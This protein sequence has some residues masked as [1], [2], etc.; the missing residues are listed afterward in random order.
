MKTVT[1]AC[2]EPLKSSKMLYPSQTIADQAAHE[3][4]VQYRNVGTMT[5]FC[6]PCHRQGQ[7]DAT[8]SF[9]GSVRNCYVLSQIPKNSLFAILIGK[10][11]ECLCCELWPIKC[12][13]PWLF[14]KHCGNTYQRPQTC[15]FFFQIPLQVITYYGLHSTEEPR[16]PPLFHH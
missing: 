12:V 1:R 7:S 6:C 4:F 14:I 10:A 13:F 5:E 15:V 8:W 16:C 2:D 3:S 9:R 11:S